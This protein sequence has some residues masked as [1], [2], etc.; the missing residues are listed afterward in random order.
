MRQGMRD[1]ASSG[2][3]FIGGLDRVLAAVETAILAYGVIAMFLNTIANV[4]GRYL[5]GQSLY[6]SE[7]LNQFLIVLV[8]F[9]GLGYATRRGRH[10]RMSAFYDTFSDKRRKVLMIVIATITGAVMFWL[11]WIS[12]EYVQTVAQSAKVT[13][14]LRVPLYLTYLWVPF[15]F[16]L[17]GIQY[18]LTVLKNVQAPGV[19][20]SWEQIDAYEEV[21]ETTSQSGGDRT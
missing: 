3:R 2:G 9:V 10:I 15:G 11:S 8:T 4:F 13:P 20:I 1:D 7:E 18:L 16:F 6:F 12:F 19:W 21:G 5:F 17:T 14:A